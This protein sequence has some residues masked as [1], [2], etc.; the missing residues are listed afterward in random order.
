MGS[1]W[2]PNNKLKGEG[3]ILYIF[4]FKSLIAS[5]IGA[6]IGFIFYYIFAS[7]GMKKVGI[8]ILA[9]CAVIGYGVVTLRVPENNGSKLSKNVGGDTLDEIVKKYM[10][11][12]K[13][14][15]IYSYS[16]E[17]KEPDYLTNQSQLDSLKEQ[18][19]RSSVKGIQMK[20]GKQ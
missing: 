5:A 12:K 3:R 16:V 20:G 10:L 2:I 11:F 1:Y 6:A 17:R 9:A 18:A 8:I 13:N 19:Q 14:R 7:I 4:T 15:K